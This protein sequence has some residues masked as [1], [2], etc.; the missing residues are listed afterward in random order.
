MK[1]IIFSVVV[2]LILAGCP[3][4]NRTLSPEGRS[5][6]MITSDLAQ[7]LPGRPLD[8]CTIKAHIE[9]ERSFPCLTANELTNMLRNMTAAAGGNCVIMT[10]YVDRESCMF[11]GGHA[12]RGIA[13]SCTEGVLKAAALK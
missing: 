5:V 13:L 12:A 2:L 4:P 9:T 8:R 11:D 3:P 6:P 10:S 1:K 7:A